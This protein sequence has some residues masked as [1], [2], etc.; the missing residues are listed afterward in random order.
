MGKL[1]LIAM[2]LFSVQAALAEKKKFPYQEITTKNGLNCVVFFD[3]SSKERLWGSCN[4]E[5]YNFKQF[6]E[7]R[8]LGIPRRQHYKSAAL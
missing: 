3:Q 1:L 5:L 8:R 7:Q 4:W 2:L 6:H